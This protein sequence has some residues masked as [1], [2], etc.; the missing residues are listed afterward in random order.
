MPRREEEPLTGE[1]DA[2]ICVMRALLQLAS[3]DAKCRV[4]RCALILL[5]VKKENL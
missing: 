2:L 4:L 5:N 3:F 1:C